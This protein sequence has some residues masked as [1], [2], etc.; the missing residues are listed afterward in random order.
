MFSTHFVWLES[1][2]IVLASMVAIEGAVEQ[3]GVAVAGGAFVSVLLDFGQYGMAS[4]PG[5]SSPWADKSP[6]TR[7]RAA[8]GRTP[9]ISM[10]QSG[11]WY[12]SRRAPG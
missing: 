3:Y 11:R 4:R 12:G 5:R 2:E 1:G 7:R 6:A 9:P 8:S 10:S